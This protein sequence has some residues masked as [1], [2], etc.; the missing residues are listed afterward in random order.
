MFGNYLLSVYFSNI[1]RQQRLTSTTHSC[2]LCSVP[3]SDVKLMSTK[4]PSPPSLSCD[5][6]PAAVKKTLSPCNGQC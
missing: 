1:S 2:A 3:T 6:Q 5:P 4:E